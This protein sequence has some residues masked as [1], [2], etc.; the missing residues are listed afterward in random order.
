VFP[1]RKN[2]AHK[3]IEPKCSKC[4]HTCSLSQSIQLLCVP[5]VWKEAR[6]EVLGLSVF[7]LNTSRALVR[8]AIAER[9]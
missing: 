5:R 4:G 7:T 6:R 8:A 1:L 9:G 3:K 2:I